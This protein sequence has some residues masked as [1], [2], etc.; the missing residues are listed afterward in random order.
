[1]IIAGKTCENKM[2]SKYND[3][4]VDEKRMVRCQKVVLLKRGKARWERTKAARIPAEP[5]IKVVSEA[6][7]NLLRYSNWKFR[8]KVHFALRGY[9]FDVENARPVIQYF[10]TTI[11]TVEGMTT[12]VQA[13]DVLPYLPEGFL[14]F[15]SWSEQRDHAATTGIEQ[16]YQV[17]MGNTHY[18]ID[19]SPCTSY[20]MA[21]FVNAA[22]DCSSST[23]KKYRR[24][25]RRPSRQQMHIPNVKLVTANWRNGRVMRTRYPFYYMVTRRVEKW[26]ELLMTANYGGDHH[27][28][29]SAI[30][31]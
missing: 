28:P 8:D 24:M 16:Y 7:R 4:N 18:M 17:A 25:L 15:F 2:L 31:R 14:I 27:Y 30:D 22:L 9:S 5:L 29:D 6:E 23:T 21:N 26:E 11:K 19:P 20:G 3:E 10:T 13:T 12:G 1:V